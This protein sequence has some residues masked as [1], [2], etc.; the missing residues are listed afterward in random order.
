MRNKLEDV[1]AGW[2]AHFE[3][4]APLSRA[5]ISARVSAAAPDTTEV[6][7]YDEIGFWGVTAKDFAA[8]LAGIST[9]N[10][11][12]RINSP[13]GDVFDGI[14]IHSAIKAHA[15]KVTARIE[16]LA[17]S[18]ASFLAL[19]ADSVE[20]D[21]N[22]FFMIHN[23]WGLAI[24]NKADMQDMAT[25]LAKIDGQIAAIYAAKTGKS[26]AAMAA[27]MDGETDGTWFNADEAKAEGF[28][29][30]IV[31]GKADD[32]DEDGDSEGDDDEDGDGGSGGRKKNRPRYAEIDARINRMRMRARIAGVD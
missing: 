29:D 31:N 8:T 2:R 25:V 9:P 15:A 4:R 22:A 12:L 3:N 27:L 23:A 32:P 11:V 20:M 26:A 21:A 17:A 24:G 6:M 10:I 5:K 1:R 14:A 7:V 28:V 30:A 13:G 18:A 16:G 19:A